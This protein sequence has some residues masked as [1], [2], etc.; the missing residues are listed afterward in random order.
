M[1]DWEYEVIFDWH[2]N[3]ELGGYDTAGGGGDERGAGFGG[4]E[5]DGYS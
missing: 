5:M 3:W 1:L 2:T 4:G